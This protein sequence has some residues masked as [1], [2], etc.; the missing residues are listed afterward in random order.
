[1]HGLLGRLDAIGPRGVF[2]L[3]GLTAATF[4][5]DRVALVGEAGHVIPPIGAQGLNLG[6]RDAAVLAE[7]VAEAA[8]ADRDPGGADALASYETARRGDVTARIWT[9]DVLNR[10][11]LS[12]LLPVHLARGAGLFA[13][14]AI[15][16]LRRAAI[17][18]GLQPSGALPRLM[19]P[20]GGGLLAPR[21]AMPSAAIG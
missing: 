11:L 6:L 4:G 3:S 14:K 21:G 20:G 15:A 18:Q 16:P 5:A 10:S 8:A 13:L 19:R 12:A 7:C 17:S 1:M 2:P 9:V